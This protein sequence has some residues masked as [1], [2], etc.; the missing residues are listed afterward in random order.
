M[1][2]L[3]TNITVSVAITTSLFSLELIALE[4][5]SKQQVTWS[6]DGNSNMRIMENS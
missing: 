2:K 1:K 4:S 6:A 3:V 5:D